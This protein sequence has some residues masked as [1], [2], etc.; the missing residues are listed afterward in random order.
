MHVLNKEIS[1]VFN[2]KS[3][4]GIISRPNCKYK[5]F[6]TLNDIVNDHSKRLLTR[7]L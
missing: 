3:I 4:F 1:L 7:L 2:F 6:D 5:T